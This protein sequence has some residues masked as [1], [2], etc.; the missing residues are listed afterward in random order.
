M[1]FPRT[2]PLPAA[3]AA[4]SVWCDVR[5]YV[6]VTPEELSSP[7][8]Y[9][10]SPTSYSGAKNTEELLNPDGLPS[11]I[12]G[13]SRRPQPTAPSCVHNALASRASGKVISCALK[14]SR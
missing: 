13:S 11:R 1:L 3:R 10:G 5:C 7:D 8:S 12:A 6:F 9:S 4:T 14:S 2:G